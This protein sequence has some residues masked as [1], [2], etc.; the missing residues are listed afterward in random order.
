M[1]WSASIRVT[2]SPSPPL[3][4]LP[5]TAMT[6]PGGESCVSTR[7]TSA[8][9]RSIR[10]SDGTPFSSIAQASSA[11]ISSAVYSGSSQP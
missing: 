11:R 4:P 1:P 7:V 3:F 8:A 6:G 10:S 5:Q 9:A 2:A